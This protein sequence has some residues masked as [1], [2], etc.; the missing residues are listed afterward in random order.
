MKLENHNVPT[1]TPTVASKGASVSMGHRGHRTVLRLV[2]AV[3]ALVV[4]SCV[5][6]PPPAAVRGGDWAPTV[7]PGAG[8][9]PGAMRGNRNGGHSGARVCAGRDLRQPGLLCRLRGGAALPARQGS[10]IEK[11][12]AADSEVAAARSFFS[13][14]GAASRARIACGWRGVQH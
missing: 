4:P 9:P 6:L 5:T 3:L 11:E 8:A 2:A 7:R 1:V 12:K 10:T 13:F 14:R